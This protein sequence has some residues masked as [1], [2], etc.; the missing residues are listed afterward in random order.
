MGIKL[1]VI[2]HTY[3][4]LQDNNLSWYNQPQGLSSRKFFGTCVQYCR[5]LISF[6]LCNGCSER[7]WWQQI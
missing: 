3:I 1:Q 4:G 2:G 6:C 7:K 5:L